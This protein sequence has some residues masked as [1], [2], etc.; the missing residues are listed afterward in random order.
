MARANE[1]ASKAYELRQ[2]VSEREKFYIESTYERSVTENL[3]AARKI[4]EEWQRTY[5][6]DDVPPNDCGV[7]YSSLRDR[8]EALAA[9][10][11][12]LR[13]D[14]EVEFL[15]QTL[16]VPILRSIDWTS[17]KPRFRKHG[18]MGLIP[19]TC[20]FACITL[21]FYRVTQPGLTRCTLPSP[22]L[23]RR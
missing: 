2:R 20:T 3:E 8:E 16:R 6:Q 22:G 1:N 9:Y 12:S 11:E 10:Q 5:P 19:Q 21:P 4:Y 13:L 23:A 14:P 15:M 7:I 18:L 17:R